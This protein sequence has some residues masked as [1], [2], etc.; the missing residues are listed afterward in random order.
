M[1]LLPL[2][3]LMMVEG[4]DDNDNDAVFDDVGVGAGVGSFNYGGIRSPRLAI[5]SLSLPWHGGCGGV[6]VVFVA[7]VVAVAVALSLSLL[8][9]SRCRCRCRSRPLSSGCVASSVLN[10]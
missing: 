2:L 4:N 8:Y 5:F 6:T 3:F 7:S 10:Q 1:L 9:H